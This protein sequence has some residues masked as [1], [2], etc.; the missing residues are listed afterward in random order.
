V[1][2]Q[3]DEHRRARVQRRALDQLKALGYDV[4][5]TPKAPAA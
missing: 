2:V 4:T 1:L 3:L 5:I